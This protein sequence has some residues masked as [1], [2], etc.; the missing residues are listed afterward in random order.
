ME[1][2]ATTGVWCESFVCLCGGR[3]Q[4]PSL[5]VESHKRRKTLGHDHP[6]DFIRDW[7]SSRGEIIPNFNEAIGINRAPHSATFKTFLLTELALG[8]FRY[9]PHPRGFLCLFSFPW[10][11]LGAASSDVDGPCSVQTPSRSMV[12]VLL[13]RARAAST[14]AGHGYAACRL[15]DACNLGPGACTYLSDD[16][17]ELIESAGRQRSPEVFAKHCKHAGTGSAEP[18]SKLNASSGPSRLTN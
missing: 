16:D 18:F 8:Y 6:E 2:G 11:Q 7:K 15:K 5:E 10:P 4:A 3:F 9:S 17:D 12:R 13:K 1:I 14:A